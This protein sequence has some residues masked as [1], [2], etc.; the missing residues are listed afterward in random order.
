MRPLSQDKTNE[1]TPAKYCFLFFH[2]AL[3]NFAASFPPGTSQV[4]VYI[5]LTEDAGAQFQSED[6]TSATESSLFVCAL[7][8]IPS[9]QEAAIFLSPIPSGQA[10]VQ[11]A[12]LQGLATTEVTH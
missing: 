7:L 6:R 4:N 10:F 12:A 1:Q 8:L 2:I 11:G 3:F 5:F 9:L